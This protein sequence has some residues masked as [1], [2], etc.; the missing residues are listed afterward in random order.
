MRTLALALGLCISPLLVPTAEAQHSGNERYEKPSRFP[1]LRKAFRQIR[2][3]VRYHAGALRETASGIGRDVSST[4]RGKRP[5]GNR[6]GYRGQTY[7]PATYDRNVY[8]EQTV[9]PKANSRYPS[10]I[11][12]PIPREGSDSEPSIVAPRG[13]EPSR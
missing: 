13:V 10:G 8:P 12:N 9:R 7:P 4:I 11:R 6:Y 5:E 2:S 3:D 1:I